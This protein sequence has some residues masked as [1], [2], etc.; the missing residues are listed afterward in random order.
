VK[1]KIKAWMIYLAGLPITFILSSQIEDSFDRG[2]F[3]GYYTFYGLIILGAY[4]LSHRLWFSKRK[5][6]SDSQ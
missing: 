1:I 6:K 3:I 4:H 2:A 5:T